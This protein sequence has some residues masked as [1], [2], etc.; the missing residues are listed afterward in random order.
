MKTMTKSFAMLAGF[1]AAIAMFAG[2]QEKEN[3]GSGSLGDATV[4]SIEPASAYA[5][6]EIAVTGTNFSEDVRQNRIIING[7]EIVPY[8][9]E[10]TGDGKY[11]LYAEV[12]TRLGSG[13]V[14][15]SVAG[16]VF[17]SNVKFEYL[18]TMKF[19]NIIGAVWGASWGN[20]DPTEPKFDGPIGACATETGQIL[21]AEQW[22]HCIRQVT[23]SGPSVA[24]YAGQYKSSG[25]QS[26]DLLTAKFDTPKGIVPISDGR[27]VVFSDKQVQVI[28][29]NQVSLLGKTRDD[30]GERNYEGAV[31][32]VNFCNT[33]G[34]AYDPASGSVYFGCA[35]VDGETGRNRHYILKWD[36]DSDQ[37]S[38]AA[39]NV[40]SDSD[41]QGTVDGDALTVAR[42]DNPGRMCVASDGALY[43]LQSSGDGNCCVR[44]LANGT[45][46]TLAGNPGTAGYADGK[47]TEALFSFKAEGGEPGGGIVEDEDGNLL[48]ADPGNHAIRKMTPDGTVTTI[49]KVDVSN[50]SPN[51]WAYKD[52]YDPAIGNQGEAS[53]YAAH[54]MYIFKIE[55]YTYG[56]LQYTGDAPGIRKIVFE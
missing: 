20:T 15:V 3:G 4:I 42:L 17:D 10:K 44:K 25:Q 39:G 28:D 43:F 21:L 26:G 14:S 2:C 38:V 46:T 31:S 11:V 9:V 55:D 1:A 52:D 49:N 19:S 8:E 41:S 53:Q 35:D 16:K 56:F 54:P 37:I 13:T 33:N 23:P 5:Y 24:L 36:L 6:D 18:K 22:T 48:I 27:Y 40:S 12:P 51:K 50:G 7:N 47:G 32:E 34:A 30:E 29:G 45:V